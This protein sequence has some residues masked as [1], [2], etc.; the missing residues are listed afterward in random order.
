MSRKFEVKNS[1]TLHTT[2][3]KEALSSVAGPGGEINLSV[4]GN[5]QTTGILE[6]LIP[7]VLMVVLGKCIPRLISTVIRILTKNMMDKLSI[8][9]GSGQ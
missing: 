6:V 9:L 2:I 1:A 4:W 8:A 7:V 3:A 5:V